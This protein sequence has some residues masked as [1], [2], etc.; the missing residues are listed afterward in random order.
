MNNNL[1]LS[2]Y[3][4]LDDS[5]AKKKSIITMIVTLVILVIIYQSLIPLI[6]EKLALWPAVI[7]TLVVSVLVACVA[8]YFAKTF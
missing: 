5:E 6:I 7:L 8:R 1:A 4:N 2:D 3:V